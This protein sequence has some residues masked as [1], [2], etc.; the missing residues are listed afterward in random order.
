VLMSD[1][2]VRFLTASTSP[3]TVCFLVTRAKGE[4]VTID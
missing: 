2:S 4:V 3:R 1:G